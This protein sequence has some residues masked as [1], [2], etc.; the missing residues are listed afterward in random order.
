MHGNVEEWTSTVYGSYGSSSQETMAM[1]K[2][3]VSRGGSHGDRV[4]FSAF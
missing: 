4:V 1:D 3:Y 2:F